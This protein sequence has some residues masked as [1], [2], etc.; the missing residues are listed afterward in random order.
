MSGPSLEGD[1][2]DNIKLLFEGREGD[3]VLLDN[4]EILE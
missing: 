2:L 3:R 1:V 4:F